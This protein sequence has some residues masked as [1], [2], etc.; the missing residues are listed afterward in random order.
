MTSDITSLSNS[1]GSYWKLVFNSP[2]ALHIFPSIGAFPWGV[3]P[4]FLQ[5]ELATLGLNVTVTRSGTGSPE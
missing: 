2:V 1:T 3:D 4:V 5:T